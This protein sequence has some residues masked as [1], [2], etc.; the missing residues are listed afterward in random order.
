LITDANLGAGL[1]PGIYEGVGG[2]IEFA[3]PGAPA[4]MTK[5]SRAPGSLAGSGLTLDLAVRNA[6]KLL[7][8]SVPDAVRM[9]STNP[10]R[11]LN[12]HH[13]RGRVRAGYYADLV[14]LGE[15]LSVE[16]TWANG[17]QVYGREERK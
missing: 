17:N 16:A 5:H 12:I 10:A 13:E 3:Y 1:P 7:G 2:E 4:R 6:V 14:L 8:V 15:G 9:A 11:V